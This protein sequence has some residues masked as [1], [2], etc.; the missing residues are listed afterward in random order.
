MAAA[1]LE[2]ECKYKGDLSRGYRH[3]SRISLRYPICLTLELA[4]LDVPGRKLSGPEPANRALTPVGEGGCALCYPFWVSSSATSGPARTL[5]KLYAPGW[6]RWTPVEPVD[7]K[8]GAVSEKA[9]NGALREIPHNPLVAGSSPA[10][11]I[12]KWL[13]RRDL[14]LRAEPSPHPVY[15]SSTHRPVDSRRSARSVDSCDAAELPHRQR[16]AGIICACPPPDRRTER[17]PIRCSAE[18][19]QVKEQLAVRT[20]GVEL[21]TQDQQIL[22]PPVSAGTHPAEENAALSPRHIPS[23]GTTPRA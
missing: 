18:H 6:K 16:V 5:R 10:G 12:R 1:A 20:G 2:A 14:P 21:I 11:G 22:C 13:K 3:A 19:S 17:A 7:T 23:A 4:Q 8:M 15:A 9:G